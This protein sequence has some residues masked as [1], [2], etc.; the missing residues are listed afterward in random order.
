M[1]FVPWNYNEARKT[2]TPSPDAKAMFSRIT[3]RH[4]CK[5]YINSSGWRM[6][7]LSL[8]AGEVLPL[9]DTSSR[10]QGFSIICVEVSN[11]EDVIVE[12]VVGHVGNVYLMIQQELNTDPDSKMICQQQVQTFPSELEE[13]SL[14]LSNP[15]VSIH[16]H[17]KDIT[18]AELFIGDDVLFAAATSLGDLCRLRLYNVPSFTNI[19][20]AK[21]KL[22]GGTGPTQ[23]TALSLNVLCKCG[24]FVQFE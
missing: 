16:V 17:R 2:W 5:I 18:K 14:S 7:Q 3:A 11:P 1:A 4:D 13:V 21:I 24:E 9:D 6:N 20:Q 19:D 12:S 8:C 23:V 10:F 22:T 15:V